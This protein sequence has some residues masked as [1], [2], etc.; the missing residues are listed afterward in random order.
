MPT[1]AFSFSVGS[2]PSLPRLPLR[3]GIA[4]EF[5]PAGGLGPAKDWVVVPS[6]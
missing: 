2:Q 3:T 1:A 5:W 6:V 4:R